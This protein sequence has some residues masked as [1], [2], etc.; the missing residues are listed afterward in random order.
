MKLILY[1]WNANNE[2]ILMDNL[3]KL[4]FEVVCFRKECRHYTRD[5]E[6]AMEMIPFIHAQGA[7]AVVSFNYFPIVSMICNTCQ[8][9]YY[10][11][12]YDCPHFTL[13]A[14]QIGLPCNHIG[15]FDREM[16]GQLEGYGVNT[17]HHVPLAV[18]TDHFEAAISQ[19]TPQE[20]ERFR[21]DISFVG[22]LYTDEHNY[23]DR[24]FGEED[25][26]KQEDMSERAVECSSRQGER[27]AAGLAAIASGISRQCFAYHEDYLRQAVMN[28]NI[29][30]GRIQVQMEKQGLM[31]GEDYYAKAEDILLAAVLEKKVTV[32]ERRILLTQMAG[33][34]AI[35]AN[36]DGAG[37]RGSNF[38]LY[39]GSDTAALPEL[40]FCNCGTVDYHTQMP[41]VFAGSRI[42]LNISLRSI[43]AGIPLRVLDIMACGG[44]V[45]SNWQPEIAE[46]FEEGVE[47]VTFDSLEDCLTKT[48]YYLSHEE[49]RRQIAAN[50]KRKV[51]E[52]FSYQVGLERLFG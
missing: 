27:P 16:V 19:A 25:A 52:K 45:L 2:Q 5:M 8:I 1:S 41:L 51:Q 36:N 48:A 34:F 24:L 15:I 22:S 20:K 10:A 32:E 23:Y 11:W 7:E 37:N 3:I 21:C 35:S 18:D 42:N 38:R 28:G 47:I 9:P 12:V 17:V 29:D 13:Y 39:T 40:D 33:R 50:G 49:E 31:L 30:L 4:G 46:Y 43:H 6:L 44:F 14:K 26:V